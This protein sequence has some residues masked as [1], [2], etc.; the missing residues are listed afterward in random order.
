MIDE[1]AELGGKDPVAVR[2]ALLKEERG[3]AVLR[4]AVELAGGLSAKDGRARGVAYCKSFSTYVAQV[5]EIERGPE[6]VPRVRKIWAAIDCGVSVN[7]NVIRAQV[8]GGIGYGL[9]HAL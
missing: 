9:G 5:A 1:L 4:R 2:L 3:K 8:E 7:P 6:G